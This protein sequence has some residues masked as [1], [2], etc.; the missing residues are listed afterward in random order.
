MKTGWYR[1]R[2]TSNC[3]YLNNTR[4]ISA[5]GIQK[6][7]FLLK[8]YVYLLFIFRYVFV[9]LPPVACDKVPVKGSISYISIH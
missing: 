6:F 8:H 3:R 2:L 7:A 4:Y 5:F 1:E 9:A